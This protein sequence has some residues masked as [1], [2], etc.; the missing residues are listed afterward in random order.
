MRTRPVSVLAAI[1]LAAL[2]LTTA[3]C[4]GSSTAAG[5]VNGSITVGTGTVGTMPSAVTG[6]SPSGSA[7]SA[8]GSTGAPST[9]SSSGSTGA[10]DVNAGK[11]K[12]A[13]G[14]CAAC[15]TLAAAGASGA[16]GP[17]FDQVKPTYQTMIGKLTNPPALMQ[18]V[19]GSALAGLSAT[20]KQNLAAYIASVEGK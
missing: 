3:G 12:F 8:G 13:S 6:S 16:V 19:M 15:H 20:D 10:G 9:G 1:G 14:G 7:P 17:N 5:T 4:G 2:G 11:A 18:S